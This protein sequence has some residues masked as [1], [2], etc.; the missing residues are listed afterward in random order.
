MASLERL[1]RPPVVVVAN[2]DEWASRSLESLLGSRGYAVL[3]VATG[4]E[5]LNLVRTMQPDALILDSRAQDLTAVEVCK[6]LRGDARVRAA[7]P[8]IMTAS[9]G[10]ARA[11]R[12]HAYGAGAWDYCTQPIDGELLLLKLATFLRAKHEVDHVT[13]ESFIDEPT[14]LYTLRGLERRAQ[15]IGAQASRKPQAVAC[16]AFAPVQ[17]ERPEAGRYATPEAPAIVERVASTCRAHGRASD[18]FARMGTT[19]FA[20]LA[21]A[22]DDRGAARLLA[23]LQSA[24]TDSPEADQAKRPAVRLVAGVASVAD[25]ST[26]NVDVMAMLVR[27]TDELRRVRAPTAE[28]AR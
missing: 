4:R 3:R 26:S 14:G 19:E 25:F 22:T 9:D 15:E 17:D 18:V 2:D 16:I 5:A 20:V 12:V 21:P 1:S 8:I 27:A 13:S 28:G 23:R 10:G 11:E 7:M 24:L 6:A